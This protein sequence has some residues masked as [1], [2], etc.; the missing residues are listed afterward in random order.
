M[1]LT[2]KAEGIKVAPGKDDKN[3]DWILWQKKM[4][5]AMVYLKTPTIISAAPSSNLSAKLA[6]ANLKSIHAWITSVHGTDLK[7]D[8][9]LA[10]SN[11]LET[12]MRNQSYPFA[13]P[14]QYLVPFSLGLV[15]CPPD[16]SSQFRSRPVPTT[17]SSGTDIQAYVAIYSANLVLPNIMRK[18]YLESPLGICANSS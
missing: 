4:K 8:G 12:M 17:R 18:M 1:P 11:R 16:P 3:S 15:H 2:R 6:E 5:M 10:C 13:L 9:L 14:I 7:N